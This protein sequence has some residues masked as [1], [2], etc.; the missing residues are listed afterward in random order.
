MDTQLSTGC[1]SKENCLGAPDQP[2]KVLCTLSSLG[3]GGVEDMA[4]TRDRGSV[5]YHFCSEF[6]NPGV[7][8]L[9]DQSLFYSKAVSFGLQSHTLV[10]SSPTAPQYICPK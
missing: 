6:E 4:M 3:R 9:E 2:H 10:R 1:L 7:Q 8:G 5:E